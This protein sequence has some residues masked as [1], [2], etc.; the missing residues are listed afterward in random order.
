MTRAFT[1]VELSI[2]IAII[3]ILAA[4]LIPVFTAFKEEKT[5]QIV[6]IYNGQE[7]VYV[8]ENGDEMELVG[9]E[10]KDGKIYMYF[11]V[12]ETKKEND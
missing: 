12:T 3:A 1:L 11:G 7:K 8:N 9:I 10:S 6:D 4:V 2:V 5:E